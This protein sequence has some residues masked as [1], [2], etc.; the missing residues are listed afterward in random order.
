MAPPP[1]QP[2]RSL[3]S[4]RTR[5]SHEALHRALEQGGAL[6]GKLSQPFLL[7]SGPPASGNGRW[8][9]MRGHHREL[10]HRNPQSPGLERVPEPLC[11]LRVCG[12][13]I[14]SKGGKLL[15]LGA[16]KLRGDRGTRPPTAARPCSGTCFEGK[17]PA[18][19]PRKASA[20]CTPGCRWADRSA[21][22]PQTLPPGRQLQGQPQLGAGREQRVLG[23]GRCEEGALRTRDGVGPLD[24]GGPA[25]EGHAPGEGKVSFPK[26][27]EAQKGFRE[28]PDLTLLSP[29]I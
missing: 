27:W 25:K 15:E 6:P 1:P 13:S 5:K 22:T 9:Q 4:R 19:D 24:Q 11:K 3:C 17:N 10:G 8:L 21:R 14:L 23:G 12:L 26:L 20:C 16:E 28:G 29:S 7:T 18:G 2:P